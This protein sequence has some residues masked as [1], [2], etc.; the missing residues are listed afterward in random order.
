MQQRRPHG[1]SNVNANTKHGSY[2]PMQQ[3]SR[4]PIH[5]TQ[6]QTNFPLSP[7]R[8]G[9][10]FIHTELTAFEK[11]NQHQTRAGL[12]SPL[13]F[14]PLVRVQL[15]SPP[16]CRSRTPRRTSSHKSV[17]V[18]KEHATMNEKT[19]SVHRSSQLTTSLTNA[20]SIGP[21]G[22]R[23]HPLHSSRLPAH[24]NIHHH[25]FH[26]FLLQTHAPTNCTPVD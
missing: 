3:A 6:V 22:H 15:L 2:I 16:P 13:P 10:P 19:S 5:R 25:L 18:T 23:C 1:N 14:R 20:T 9:G 7:S 12:T 21:P 17:A 26:K 8:K 24:I 11:E 4:R